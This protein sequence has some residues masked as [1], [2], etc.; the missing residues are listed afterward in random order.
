MKSV[1]LIKSVLLAATL[2]MPSIA[3]AAEDTE[4]AKQWK[5]FAAK[6]GDQNHQKWAEAISSDKAMALAK[7]WKEFRGYDAH[8]LIAEA[9]IPAELKPG[10]RITKENAGNYPWLKD[11]LPAPSL[12]QLLD[13]NWFS[14]KE[15]V[16]V[17][18]SNYSMSRGRLDANKEARKNNITVSVNEK[19]ELMNSNGR[20]ALTD[21]D[22]ASVVPFPKPAN[23]MD[24][25]WNFVAHGVGNDNV[26]F[27][28]MTS[29]I[30]DK[31]NEVERH[32]KIDLWWQKFHGR[33]DLEPKG[34]IPDTDGLIEGGAVFFREPFDVRG[35]A[36]VRKRYAS[37]D[38]E[39]DFA[40]F[41]PSLRRTRLLSASDAQDPLASGMGLTW[42]D[43]R[44]YWQKT[45]PTKFDYK[46]VGEG[47]VLTQA[48]AG[49]FYDSMT[50]DG[51]HIERLEVELRPVW[52]YEVID[53]GGRYQYSTRR[54]YI[55]KEFYY[56]QYQETYDP[57]G[58]LFRV[59]EDQR[60]YDPETGLFQWRSLTIWNRVSHRVDFV[61]MDSDW[62]SAL[63][64]E[65]DE[66]IFDIDQLRDFQ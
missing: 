65:V 1:Q 46:M 38:R 66:S 29:D 8:S 15:I 51:C 30:C 7:D 12:A 9:D 27:R 16:I 57:R 42:D 45:D 55:D 52:I 14:W 64:D 54:V 35:L 28:P 53:K 18:T 20:F 21:P 61:E 25:N 37:M 31:N 50:R 10:L 4:A 36:G 17:P 58:N 2:A 26:W 59:Y 23:G 32:Y 13:E 48:D 19:G 24:V 22:T 60:D 40:V 56:M 63:T 11:F 39:D 34:D 5:A 47:F 33:T 6:T 49:H 43:W 3:A 62:S 41:I 44:G